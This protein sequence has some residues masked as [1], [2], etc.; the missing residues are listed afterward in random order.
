MGNRESRKI[1]VRPYLLTAVQL[2]FLTHFHPS[3]S[4]FATSLLA[5]QRMP[6]K[7]DLASHS[8]T[9][10]LDRYV[11]RNA[12]AST[13][14]PHGSS[15]MQPLAGGDTRGIL[16]S[17]K[18]M[19]SEIQTV[20]SEAFWHKKTEDVAV[21][22]VF[23][24]K[25]FSQIGKKRYAAA[26]R[27][28]A[29]PENSHDDRGDG[30]EIWQVFEESRPEVELN[31]GSD[32]D[33]EDLDSSNAE[34]VNEE[35]RE[36]FASGSGEDSDFFDVDEISNASESV[37]RDNTE[38]EELFEDGLKSSRH[39]IVNDM[40]KGSTRAK[41]RKLENLPT[42]ASVEEYADLLGNEEDLDL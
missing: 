6:S 32:M 34:S 8:L 12:K 4:M 27:K 3:V 22:E 42:F 37:I 2:P 28:P 7:P 11:Y 23:F 35:G 17:N 10:F 38:D 19:L 31:D 1:S 30:D 5:D 33:M 15:I 20:N 9:H 25:Y 39:A 26:N 41:R 40:E 21:D 16:L 29:K 14:K 13:G 24:H 18:A 36:I